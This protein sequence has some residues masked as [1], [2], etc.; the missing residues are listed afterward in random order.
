[1]KVLRSLSLADCGTSVIKGTWCMDGG[2]VKAYSVSIR[3][4]MHLSAMF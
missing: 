3:A 2:A 4:A 1:M